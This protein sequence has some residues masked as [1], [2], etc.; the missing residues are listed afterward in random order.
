MRITS[1]LSFDASISQLQRRQQELSELQLQLTTGKRVSKASDDPAAAARAE[2]ALAAVTR[3]DAN[4]RALQA[5]R[6]ALALT[7]SALGAAGELVQQAREF[8]VSAG[9]GSYSDNDRASIA[10][11]LRGLRG[12]LLGVANRS[13][14][15]GRYLFG[16]QGVGSQPL[17][18][19]PEGVRYVATSGSLQAMAGEATGLSLD[20]SAVWL[21][22]PDPTGTGATLSLF[23]VMDRVVAELE[24]PGRGGVAVAAT[25]TASLRDLDAVAANLSGS[26]ARAGEQLVR[27][28]GIEDR[29]AQRKLDAQGERASAEDLDM[30]AAISDFQSRQSGYDAAMKTYSIVQRMSLM[31]YIK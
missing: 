22:A 7:E 12:D 20:G 4:Q 18:D 27:L 2:R 14:G 13:D 30:V 31:D 23:D 11:A 8:V 15:A 21:N 29:L 9:N 26:R 1:S 17:V 10:Q 3:S 24:T 19:T 5:S 25:V 16:G 28:D 6:N